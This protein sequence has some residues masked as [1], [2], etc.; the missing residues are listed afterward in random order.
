MALL[1]TQLV[2]TLVM[3]SIIQKLGPH[4]SL[5]RWILCSTGLVRYLYPT[6]EELRALAGV[7]K[8][9][10]KGKKSG[11]NNE[12]G[13]TA[14]TFHIPRNLDIKLETSKVTALDVVHLKFYSEYQWLLDFAVYSS[15][16]YILTEV[17]H[18]L[19]PP[20]DEVNL[21]MLWCSLV[22]GFSFKL[23]LSLTY[24]YF[25][26]QESVGERSTVIITAFAYLLIVMVILIVDENSLE[27]GLNTAYTSFNESAAAFLEMQGLD[28]SG[29]ASKIVLKFFLALWCA[30]LGALFTFPGLRMAKM[31]WDSLRYCSENRLQRYLLNTSFA[32]PFILVLLWVKPVSRD[33]L[34]NRIFH[35]MA[36][37]LL[38]EHAFETMRL[39][40]IVAAVLLRLALMPTY[41]QAYLNMAYH[42]IQEQKKEAGRITNIELQ[43]KIAAVFYYLCVVTLQFVA[44]LILCLYLTFMY[45]TLGNYSWS[46]LFVS[47]VAEECFESPSQFMPLPSLSGEQSIQQSA[48]QFTLALDSLKQVFTTDVFRGLFGFATWWCC[49]AWFATSS[50]GMVY[51]SYFSHS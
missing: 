7:P 32:S 16:V 27:L 24:Q 6:D 17:Y 11:R 37:P 2:I 45:K 41:L 23:L 40:M 8:D 21:S 4:Y 49:F 20:K 30:L 10:S 25:Q 5:A 9:K 46:G 29:P 47:P 14:E 50:L 51:Q 26:S 28:S 44:P 18:A 43:K 35:G 36:T 34:T 38:T 3:V 33:Y 39:I 1:G 22:V 31:H 48:K 19:A 42:R 13:K 15:V 12:N